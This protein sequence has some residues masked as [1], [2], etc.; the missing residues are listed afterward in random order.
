M[1]HKKDV[2]LIWVKFYICRF[3]YEQDEILGIIAAKILTKLT[4]LSFLFVDLHMN[5]TR[6]W[7]Q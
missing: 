4:K 3:M 1:S 7:A 6:Y 2:R 5:K